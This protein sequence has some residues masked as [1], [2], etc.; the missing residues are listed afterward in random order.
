MKPWYEST[1][2]T[3]TVTARPTADSVRLRPRE[4]FRLM[5]RVDAAMDSGGHGQVAGVCGA[6]EGDVETLPS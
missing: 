3:R 1:I 4:A 5:A 2:R 6:E